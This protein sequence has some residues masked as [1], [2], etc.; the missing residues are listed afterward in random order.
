[1]S[2]LDYLKAFAIILVIINHSWPE[3]LKDAP[4]F[5]FIIRMAVPIF[6]VVSGYTFAMS[7]C[8]YNNFKGMYSLKSLISKFVRFTVP[9]IITYLLFIVYKVA[10]TGPV[11]IKEIVKTFIM[12]D[13]GKGSYYYA[14]LI[15]LLLIFP[16]IY[17]VMKKSKYGLLA[18][19]AVNLVYEIMIHII[20]IGIPLYRIV[21]FRYLLFVGMGSFLYM[22][23]N[24]INIFVL[25]SSFVI[26][27]I[28]LLSYNYLGY[29][30][31]LFT[32]QPWANTSMI[33]AFYIFPFMYVACYKFKDFRFRGLT[34]KLLSNIGK[35]SYQILFVQMIYFWVA[36]RFYNKVNFPLVVQIIINVGICTTIGII[37]LK[38]D[39]IMV[40]AINN[41][42]V[43]KNKN[44]KI[45][46]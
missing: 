36:D 25:I 7:Y 42:L 45:S 8:K 28:Y 30:L 40:N 10:Q 41:I 1:M 27:S 32:Y 19:G 11:G 18:I 24:R 15:Q 22:Y 44:F 21:F 16:L 43:P 29:E 39:N 31:K 13:Y 26:G 17:A 14:L 20:D 4:I 46:A 6:M 2:I 37:Y 9:V 23:R 34:D 12:S 35:A 33:S 38:Y 5:I 3:S